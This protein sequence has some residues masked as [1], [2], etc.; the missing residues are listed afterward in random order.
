M[1]S[2]FFIGNIRDYL[3]TSHTMSLKISILFSSYVIQ[4]LIGFHT[5]YLSQKET[6]IWNLTIRVNILQVP[7]ERL[8]LQ[9]VSW[10]KSCCYIPII[11]L[12]NTQGNYIEKNLDFI[13]P[14]SVSH[15]LLLL[16]ICPVLLETYKAQKDQ[17]RA[18]FY[19]FLTL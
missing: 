5:W 19:R 7:K 1:Y 2:N 15:L 18:R 4:T 10:T 16:I 14:S 11:Y 3:I 17:G 8:I 6:V 13:N 12:C 9:L